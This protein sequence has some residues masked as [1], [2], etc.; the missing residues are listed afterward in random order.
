MIDKISLIIGWFFAVACTGLA[1]LSL[2]LMIVQYDFGWFFSLA[3]NALSGY[4]NSCALIDYYKR[5]G[6]LNE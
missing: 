4:L 6:L 2:I 3:A 1:L 5:W